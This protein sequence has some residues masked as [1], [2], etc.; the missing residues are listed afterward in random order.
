MSSQRYC[1]LHTRNTISQQTSQPRSQQIH[2]NTI[3][4]KICPPSVSRAAPTRNLLYG[5]YA[6]S[7][8]LKHF[9]IN[10]SSNWGVSSRPP[11]AD[12]SRCAL[13]G[14]LKDGRMLTVRS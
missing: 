3:P 1:C 10:S 8:A 4:V 6:F 9:W 13:I 2:S 12:I 7:L 5:L 14:I 11:G